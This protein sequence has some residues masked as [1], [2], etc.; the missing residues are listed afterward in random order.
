[1]NNLICP[2]RALSTASIL[3]AKGCVFEKCAIWNEQLQ[4]CS[5]KATAMLLY[6]LHGVIVGSFISQNQSDEGHMK[7]KEESK[8]EEEGG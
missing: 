5:H 7:F 2:Y 1:M 3:Q 4:M 6:D 8:S